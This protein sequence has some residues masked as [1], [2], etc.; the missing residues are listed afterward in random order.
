MHRPVS[1]MT[2]VSRCALGV[3]CLGL[4]LG[5][6]EDT[7]PEF[8]EGTYGAL[9]RAQIEVDCDKRVQCAERTQDYLREDAFEDCASREAM[10]LNGHPEVRLKFQ[11]GL[12]RCTQPDVCHYVACVDSQFVSFGETQVDKLNYVCAQKVQ[13][14]IDSSALASNA[15]EAFESC[16]ISSVLAV[17][18][19][20]SESQA[21]FQAQYFL[22]VPMLSCAFTTC[23]PY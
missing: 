14:A 4:L 11:I 23:F 15:Q 17:D 19:F 7:P 21:D 3:A 12:A 22:C 18:T 13:C 1:E 8:A 5:C 6:S 2:V 10:T 16:V 9:H 20:A